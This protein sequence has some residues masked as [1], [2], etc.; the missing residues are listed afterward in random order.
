MVNY[1]NKIFIQYLCFC[2]VVCSGAVV[3]MGILYLL[4]SSDMLKLNL[5]LNKVIA[6][7][8]AIINNFFWNNLW[9]FRNS[10][11]KEYN[12]YTILKR[13]LNFNLICL[14]GIF[15]SVVILTIEAY[16]LKI[17][18]FLANF[19]SIVVVSVW[20]FALS[21]KNWKTNK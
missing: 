18:V 21:A 10:F 12:R 8:T 14:S 17:N 11:S 16:G 20:N 5:I 9:T 15:L 13:F 3:D 1:K 7:E 6:A 19:I 2:L 4:T